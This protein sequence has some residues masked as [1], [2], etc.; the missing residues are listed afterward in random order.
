MITLKEFQ[1]HLMEQ[2]RQ[3]KNK[4]SDWAK[5]GLKYLPEKIEE[6]SKCPFCQKA[7][8][9]KIASRIKK[10]YSDESYQKK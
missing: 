2:K 9:E 8:T 10:K 3:R 6:S 4:K 5:R 1:T 7:I